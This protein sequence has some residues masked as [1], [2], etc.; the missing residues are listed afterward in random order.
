MTK[1]TVQC[2][3]SSGLGWTQ[4]I[5]KRQ[6]MRLFQEQGAV[7][8]LS[9]IASTKSSL[10]RPLPQRSSPLS[11]IDIPLKISKLGNPGMA[12]Q[13]SWTPNMNWWPRMYTEGFA[14]AAAVPNIIVFTTCAL[15]PLQCMISKLSSSKSGLYRC[16]AHVSILPHAAQRMSA[17]T[18]VHDI[19]S[20]HSRSLPN[21]SLATAEWSF[22]SSCSFN[23]QTLFPPGWECLGTSCMPKS[24]TTL[25]TSHPP[26]Q[27]VS[28]TPYPITVSY[29]SH[30]HLQVGVARMTARDCVRYHSIYLGM[31]TNIVLYSTIK[32]SLLLLQ[33]R[34]KLYPMAKMW[35]FRPLRVKVK[36]YF[37]FYI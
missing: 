9:K 12:W 30:I 13:Q 29:A 3:M 5:E 25:A 27:R 11:H 37:I 7:L 10:R 4:I 1:P 2:V 28:C 17:L 20:T 34:G 18:N 14:F 15:L 32:I 6:K 16:I 23:L 24:P 26:L 22:G 8:I 31:N 21:C 35:L 33:I 36:N 19:P